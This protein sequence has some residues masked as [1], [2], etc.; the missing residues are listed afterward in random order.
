MINGGCL[1]QN[2]KGNNR[3]YFVSTS[4]YMLPHQIQK[5][6]KDERNAYLQVAGVTPNVELR[7][8][9][10]RIRRDDFL[11]LRFTVNV[12]KNRVLLLKNE[13]GVKDIKTYILRETLEG[14]NRQPGHQRNIENIDPSGRFGLRS[15]LDKKVDH[16]LKNESS[17]NII[18]NRRLSKYHVDNLSHPNT[19]ALLKTRYLR[20]R[21]TVDFKGEM[22]L[23]DVFNLVKEKPNSLT[24]HIAIREIKNWKNLLHNIELV[25]TQ[26]RK[27]SKCTKIVF[28]YITRRMENREMLLVE[29]CL[30]T[31]KNVAANIA[32][33]KNY[34]RE[35]HLDLITDDNS[36]KK[37]NKT[38]QRP[39]LKTKGN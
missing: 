37:K 24:I 20:K 5:T 22:M 14:S 10:S 8:T 30:K 13:L 9:L 34:C 31:E 1:Y 33:L 35:K 29:S 7:E 21:N 17:S 3:P 12:I 18:G 27:H 32:R 11:T 19:R 28:T 15:D 36:N 39:L 23:A 16:C 38:F 6:E 2:G 4:K 25:V 26:V